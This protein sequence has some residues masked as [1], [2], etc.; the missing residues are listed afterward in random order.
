MAHNLRLAS[1][2]PG[3]PASF[4]APPLGTSPKGGGFS[5][6]LSVCCCTRLQPYIQ[7]CRATAAAKSLDIWKN[8]VVF[9]HLV[10]RQSRVGGQRGTIVALF[11]PPLPEPCLHLF[12]HTALRLTRSFLV[13]LS[14][15]TGAFHP[16]FPSLLARLSPFLLCLAFPGSLVGRHSYGYCGDSVAMR[17]SPCRQSRIPVKSNV[18]VS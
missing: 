13:G 18:S 5:C 15:Q 9:F 6:A 4:E 11:R 17:V 16:A 1:W 14:F 3:T 10:L 8:T 2:E 7:R 12:M